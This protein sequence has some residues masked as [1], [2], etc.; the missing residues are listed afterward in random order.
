MFQSNSMCNGP[1]AARCTVPPDRGHLWAVVVTGGED[2]HRRAL[3]ETIECAT[4]LAS[5]DRTVVVTPSG[6]GN[7]LAAELADSD[8]PHVLVQPLDRGS[9]AA[10]L[11]A[12]HWIYARDSRATV[13]VFRSDPLLPGG[14]AFMS[15]V[16]AA[17][18]YARI[19][20]RSVVLL[21][22]RAVR[23]DPDV[24]WIEPAECIGSIAPGLLYRVGALAE[25]PGPDA[26]PRLYARGGLWDTSVFACSLSALIEAGQ[27][28]VP[29][30]HDR[31]LRL[32]VFLGSASESWAVEQ[33]YRLM[34]RADF[35]AAVLR[36][37]LPWLA[38]VSMP[39]PPL[40]ERGAWARSRAA[41]NSAPPGRRL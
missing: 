29:M 14:A 30:L 23:A 24:A 39:A 2:V 21:G 28:C 19:H 11:L 34:P 10:V 9:A 7:W 4:L 25:S 26:A 3:R 31:L 8:G 5:S 32:A 6:A 40:A 15:T 1:E 13:A 33:A 27:R 36:T 16:W 20:E 38:V 35:A 12:A 22:V 41:S 17:A 18:E 37:S